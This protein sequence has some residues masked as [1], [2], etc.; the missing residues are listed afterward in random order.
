MSE[1]TQ[2]LSDLCHEVRSTNAGPFW[3]TVDIFVKHAEA[4]DLVADPD[5]LDER[6]IAG[7]Y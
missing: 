1:T 3:V 2:T 6:R 4:Y 5:Y 7:L